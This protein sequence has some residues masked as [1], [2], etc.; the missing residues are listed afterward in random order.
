MGAIPKLTD[1]QWKELLERLTLHAA[2]KLMRLSWR[3]ARLAKG[4]C[5][6]GAA[7]AADFAA[8]AIL[9]VID[10]SRMWDA[11]TQPDLLTFLRGVVDSKISHLVESAENRVTRRVLPRTDDDQQLTEAERVRS[12]DPSPD[13]LVADREWG[14]QFRAAIRK[15]LEE[16]T[17]SAGLLDCLDAGYEDRGEIATL[18]GIQVEDVYNAQKRLKKRVCAVMRKFETRKGHERSQPVR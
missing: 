11:A 6:P 4:G 7:E 14:Q 1:E 15:E 10:G 18:L 8:E 12:N 13:G 3:G 9:S 16:D 5:P 17:I 2:N